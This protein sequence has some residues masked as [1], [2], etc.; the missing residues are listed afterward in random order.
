MIANLAFPASQDGVRARFDVCDDAIFDA[1]SAFT[2]R[3]APPEHRLRFS[4]KEGIRVVHTHLRKYLCTMSESEE[5]AAKRMA[6]FADLHAAGIISEPVLKNGIVEFAFRSPDMAELIEKQGQL[7]EIILYRDFRNCGYFDDVA[8]GVK[9][10]WNNRTAP[11]QKSDFARRVRLRLDAAAP[12]AHLPVSLEEYKKAV[13]A[14][15]KESDGQFI[16][17]TN[18]E[19]D[20]VAMRGVTPVFVSCKTSREIKNEFIYEID[21]ISSHFRGFGGLAASLDVSKLLDGDSVKEKATV[22]RAKQQEVSYFGRETLTDPAVLQ[23]ALRRIA[24][25]ETWSVM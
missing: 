13:A 10:A 24:D 11:N 18:N 8:T 19:L 20:V 3:S 17:N 2:G 22:F 21:A 14:A 5:T 12:D 4:P 7:F 1:L 23:T 25:G 16:E 9:I 15:S 6:F